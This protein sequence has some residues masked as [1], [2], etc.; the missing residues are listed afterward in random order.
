MIYKNCLQVFDVRKEDGVKDIVITIT[1][2]ESDQVDVTEEQASLLRDQGAQLVWLYIYKGGGPLEDE[3]KFME[4]QGDSVI[5][6]DHFDK[7][8]DDI[9]SRML[10]ASCPGKKKKSKTFFLVLMF[11]IFSF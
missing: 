9:V 10:V 4:E 8:T 2:G 3:K 1:D 7:L 6:V 5:V 11:F